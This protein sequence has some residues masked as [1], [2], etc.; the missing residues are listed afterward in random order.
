MALISNGTTVASGGSVTVSSSAVASGT[1]GI[2]AGA[3][4]SYAILYFDTGTTYGIGTAH[5]SS[6]M[7]WSNVANYYLTSQPSGTWRIMF[8]HN[9]GAADRRCGLFLRIS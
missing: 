9:G 7:Y 1:A 8:L 3:V 4:G 6:A 2:T 5:G